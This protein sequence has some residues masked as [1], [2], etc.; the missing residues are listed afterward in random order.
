MLSFPDWSDDETE[1]VNEHDLTSVTVNAA[2]VDMAKER[3]SAVI[4]DH[5]AAP[6]RLAHILRNLGKPAVAEFVESLLPKNSS[7]R[8]GDLGEIIATEYIEESGQYT[9]P[10]RRFRWKDHRDMAM[11]GEDAI[12]VMVPG[13]GQPINFLKVEVKSRAA[14]QTSVVKEARKALDASDGLPTPHALQ[15]VAARAYESGNEEIADAIDRVSLV[16]GI[17]PQYVEHMLFAFSGNNPKGFLKKDLE[18]YTGSITQKSVGVRVQKHQQFIADVFEEA[19][20][21]NES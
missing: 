8:S 12:G 11:R 7:S 19:L 9:V 20:G 4:P 14:L 2:S 17:L 6:D 5:Y 16:E 1:K 13:K 15:F 18:G 21:A 10:V 3:L